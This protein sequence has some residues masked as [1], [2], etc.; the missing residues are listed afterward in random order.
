M[1]LHLGKGYAQVLLNVA[2]GLDPKV[3]IVHFQKSK[4]L[5]IETF[6]GDISAFSEPGMRVEANLPVR[7]AGN[8]KRNDPYKS[9]NSSNWWFPSR[10]NFGFIPDS[11]QQRD[12]S[13]LEF[14]VPGC[15]PSSGAPQDRRGQPP[16][17]ARQV[18]CG[19]RGGE[20]GARGGGWRL[21]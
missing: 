20:G 17:R 9:S 1:L 5:N 14:D 4:D 8:E 2:L 7:E 15:M 3:F 21:W 10:A 13:D 6:R 11:H 12:P 16:E 19:H 18:H